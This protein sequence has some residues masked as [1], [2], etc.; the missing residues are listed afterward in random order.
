M[1]QRGESLPEKRKSIS[2]W[3][4][5]LG[6]IIGLLVSFIASILMDYYAE[7]VENNPIILVAIFLVVLFITILSTG[8]NCAFCIGGTKPIQP[9][10]KDSAPCSYY[11]F[12]DFKKLK[13]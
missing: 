12:R 1:E 8:I 7:L 5:V 4:I 6:A 11:G 13:L 10:N 9:T 2:I 3:D